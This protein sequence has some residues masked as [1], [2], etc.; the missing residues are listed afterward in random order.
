[1]EI[2]VNVGDP[3]SKR[4]HTFKISEEDA[5]SIVGKKIGD[6]IRG[7]LIGKPGYELVI[8]GGSDSA[9]FPMRFDVQGAVRRQLLVVRSIGNRQTRKGQRIRKTVSGNTVGQ[10][11]SQ[12]NVKVTK[13]GKDPLVAPEAAPEPP[14]EAPPEQA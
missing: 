7:E 5:R 10:N 14:A 11:T 2:T 6:T 1:M 4:T 12:L 13:H 8:T 9:G 3:Q